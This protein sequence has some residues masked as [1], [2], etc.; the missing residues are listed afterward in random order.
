MTRELVLTIL[1][2][3]LENG[4]Y[5]NV[6]I[7]NT[8]AKYQ[9]LEKQD[10]SFMTRLSEGVIERVIELDYVIDC[11]SKVKTKKMKPVIRNLLRMGTYQILY[12]DQVPDSAA[13]NESVKLAGKKGF[14]NLKGFVNGILRNISR[15]KEEISYPNKEK[16]LVEHLKVKYSMP[17][18]IIKMWLEEYSAQVVEGILAAFFKEKKTTIRCNLTKGSVEQLISRLE[19]EKVMVDQGSYLPYAL[20]IHHYNY[21]GELSAFEEGLF[22]VQDESSMLIA[23]VA[24]IKE[25]D[26]VLDVCAAPGGKSTHAGELLNGTGQVLARDLTWQK[27]ELIEENRKRLGLSN[28]EPQCMDALEFDE[29]S[30]GVADVLFADLPCSGIGVMHK[31]GDIK[32]KTKEVDIKALAN[33]QR[34]IL[35]IVSQYVK[36]G[37]TLIYSTCTINSYENLDNALWFQENFPFRMVS[38]DDK[39]PE[40]LEGDTTEKGYLQ[41][42]PGI[43][44]TDGF[45]MAKFI[46][47]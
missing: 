33:I 43:H 17:E 5:S 44:Q 3:V 22:Q 28:V 45:F 12:M 42:L 4:G 38:L 46:K 37:G 24:G 6:V 25:G 30:V 26:M 11:F 40:R 27:V 35:T 39:L 31:K 19:E 16:N 13:C 14:T 18:W 41:L 32:Y 36:P 20:S 21:L 29:K 15:Q 23:Q 34:E 47:Q 7:H 1:M 2:E 10:R 9:Y 8:L